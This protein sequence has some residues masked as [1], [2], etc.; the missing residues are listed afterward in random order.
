MAFALEDF[1]DGSGTGSYWFI[2]SY[3]VAALIMHS[4]V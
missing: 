2:S 1:A 4:P 3:P